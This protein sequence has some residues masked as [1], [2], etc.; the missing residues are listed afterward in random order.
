MV[1]GIR[2]DAG[3]PNVWGVDSDIELDNTIGSE[4]AILEDSLE[5]FL[6][7]GDDRN[8]RRVYVKG[9]LIGGVE[10]RE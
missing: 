10:F 5:R 8:I 3:N 7:C 2:S 4:R 9:K 6:F 1:V